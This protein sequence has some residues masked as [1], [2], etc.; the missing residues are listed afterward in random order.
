MTF[1]CI[2][3]IIKV[4]A[5]VLFS[6]VIHL[7]NIQFYKYKSNKVAHYIIPISI[8]ILQSC[9]NIYSSVPSSQYTLW[10]RRDS[11]YR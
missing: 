7:T 6:S 1:I 3:S 8:Q 4:L 10:V 2:W 5:R 9:S 11:I